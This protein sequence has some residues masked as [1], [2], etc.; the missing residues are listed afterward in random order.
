M[1]LHCCHSETGL[2]SKSTDWMKKTEDSPKRMSSR[3]KIRIYE[4]PNI[5]RKLYGFVDK[6]HKEAMIKIYKVDNY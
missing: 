4:W 2:A 5:K 3:A 1:K 6:L